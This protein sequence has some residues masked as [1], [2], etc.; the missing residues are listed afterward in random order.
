VQVADAAYQQ[1]LV[2]AL[3][4]NEG[5]GQETRWF[6]GSILIESDGEQCWLK[7]YRGRVI[8]VLDFTPP[9]GYTFKI[10]APAA[11]WRQLVEGE[12]TFADLVTPGTRY[13]A[14]RAALEQA[15]GFAPPAIRIEG[16]T[17][18]AYRIHEAIFH[19]GDCIAATAAQ[20]ARHG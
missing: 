11:R 18:E 12:R 14:D 9:L 16:N 13:F 7:V 8:D 15:N 20:E 10:S 5:F 6:D 17:L 1:R 2:D 3:N 19:L 4:A